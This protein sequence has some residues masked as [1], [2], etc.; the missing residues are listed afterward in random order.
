MI[1]KT[2]FAHD[3]G[4]NTATQKLNRLYDFCYKEW[5]QF[6]S[7]LFPSDSLAIYQLEDV[8]TKKQKKNE[9]NRQ[10]RELVNKKKNEPINK[11][12]T[13]KVR[14]IVHNDISCILI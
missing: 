2:Y 10:Y 7:K 4:K 1:L 9:R 8:L 12:S 14:Y 3:R 11:Q 6:L 13:R 5:V